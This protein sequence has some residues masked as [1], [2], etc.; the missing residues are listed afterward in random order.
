MVCVVKTLWNRITMR[1]AVNDMMKKAVGVF[2][3]GA[4]FV[5]IIILAYLRVGS[6]LLVLKDIAISVG[7]VSM[8]FVGVKLFFED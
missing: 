7:L 1:M 2:L 4:F 3:M 8:L 5:C 6:I